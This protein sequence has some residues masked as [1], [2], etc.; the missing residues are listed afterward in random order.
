MFGVNTCANLRGTSS[1][2]GEPG[3]RPL[4]RSRIALCL[5]SRETIRKTGVSGRYS[6]KT[7]LRASVSASRMAS[8]EFD[9]TGH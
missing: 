3:P 9:F 4:N 8:S 6:G 1:S 7:L 5:D 2:S